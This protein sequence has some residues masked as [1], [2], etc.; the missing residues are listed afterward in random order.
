M[1]LGVACAVPSAKDANAAKAHFD[2]G[3]AF[4]RKKEYGK[5][6]QEYGRAIG[7]KPDY[8]EAYSSRAW[9]HYYS[10]G[11][12]KA[13]EDFSRAISLDPKNPEYYY[14]RGF[15]YAH[16]RKWDSRPLAG[17]SQARNWWTYLYNKTVTS[18]V[19]NP[20]DL[21]DPAFTIQFAGPNETFNPQDIRYVNWR[22]V[23]A[24]NTA[25]NPPVSPSIETFSLS[26]RWQQQ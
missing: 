7:L 21:M 10:S 5:A 17:S 20:N 23:A 22:F 4:F 12:S 14:W 2:Q 8:A 3:K 11:N 15:P 26:F 19:E 16:M 9:A 6:I 1:L 13:I 25:A 24:N 18:Y